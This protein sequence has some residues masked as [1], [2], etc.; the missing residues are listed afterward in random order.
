MQ[1]SSIEKLLFKLKKDD[2]EFRYTINIQDCSFQLTDVIEVGSQM[3]CFA[4]V[5]SKIR[6][7]YKSG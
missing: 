6:L 2:I 3:L 4:M 7:F 5:N 1:N